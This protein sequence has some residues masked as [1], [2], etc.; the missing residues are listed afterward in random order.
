MPARNAR[1]QCIRRDILPNTEKHKMDFNIE[2]QNS[3]MFRGNPKYE[4]AQK[5]TISKYFESK[6]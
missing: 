1:M 4:R 6:S 5:M 3:K 2:I